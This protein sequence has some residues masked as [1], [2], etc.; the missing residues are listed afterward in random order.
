M[1]SEP[2]GSRPPPLTSLAALCR[3]Y[4][5]RAV[6]AAWLLALPGLAAAH[7][8]SVSYADWT[9]SADGRE[10]RLELRLPMVELN[11]ASLDPADPAL[12]ETL[13][14]ALREGYEIR[15]TQGACANDRA[16][17]Q[18][19]GESW[20]LEARWHC[21]SAAQQLRSQFLLDRIPGHLQLAQLHGPQGSRGPYALSAGQPRML[22]AETAAARAPPPSLPRYLGLGVEHILSGWDHLTFLLILVLGAATLAQLAWRVTGFTLGHSLTLVLATLGA[23]RPPSALIEAFIAL[24]IACTAAERLLAGQARAATQATQAALLTGALALAGCLAGVLPWLLLPAAVLLSLGGGA[25]PRLD[26]LRSALFGLFHGFGFAGLL[27]TLTPDQNLPALPLFGFNL[28]VELGQLLFVL[29][30]YWLAQRWPRGRDGPWLP[31]AVLALGCGW[32]F[33]RLA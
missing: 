12:A 3:H 6:W 9:Q 19:S 26:S 25:D 14:R 22:L 16:Q 24:T 32:Y 21:R 23:V 5:R 18:R 17:A 33:A 11:R 30:V 28:G 31:A 13:A 7:S 27:A 1:R 20:L 15:D 10:L 4:G 2:A 8:R 29:P